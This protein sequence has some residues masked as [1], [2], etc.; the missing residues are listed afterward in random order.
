MNIL[1]APGKYIVAV[2]GGVD[3]V[4]L[5]DLLAR[6]ENLDL[7]VAHF[8]HGI[9]SDSN[10]DCDFVRNLAV[11][12]GLPFESE[13][14]NLGK[15]ASEE[16]ARLARYKFLEKTLKKHSAK[17]IIT[18]H[19]QDDVI[20]TIL[21]NI[22]RGTGRKGL[23]SLQNTNEILRPLTSYQKS[24]ILDYAKTNDLAWREDSTNSDPKYLRNNLR[25]NV[26]PKMSA[27]EKQEL[28]DIYN[29][30]KINNAQ[31]DEILDELVAANSMDKKLLLALDHK[32]GLE[33]LA[34]WLRQNDLRD[35]DSKTLERVLI[36]AKTLQPGKTIEAKKGWRVK[37]AK[38]QLTLI[39]E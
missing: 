16:T 2:S 39:K 27:K 34:H 37:V 14:G 3:S 20:E 13:S 23:S 31:I 11:S 35:F 25:L 26:I 36:G 29:S 7:V 22:L 17:A 28:L 15:D 12:Y 38:G 32:M 10:K 19:H 4:V 18:A 6:Q 30:A 5:L 1:V 24:Q 21:I 33:V 9:R 8:D